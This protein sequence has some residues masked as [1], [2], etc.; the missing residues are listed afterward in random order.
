M[1]WGNVGKGAASG[2]AAGAAIGSVVPVIGTA[3]GAVA[4][5]IIGGLAGLFGGKKKKEQYAGLLDV[6]PELVDGAGNLNKELAQ[7]LINTKQVDDNT[8]QLIQNALDWSDAMEAANAQIKE[9][10]VELAGDLGVSLKNSIVEAWKAGED[11][12]KSMF[13][14]ASKSLEKFV[15]DLLYSTIFSEVFDEFGERLAK[16]LSPS[17]DGDI[18]DDYDWLMDEMNSRDDYFISLLEQVKNRAKERGFSAWGDENAIISDADKSLTGAVKGVTEETASLLA[19]QINAIRIN[20]VESTEIIRQQLFHLANI[21][22]NTGAI[23]VNTR[24][25]KAIY[26]KM[27]SGGDPLRSK[28]LGG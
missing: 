20:Q 13:D 26:D 6:F 24:Y 25:I 27:S 15:E 1:D 16:S 2:A 22:Q 12:S 23:D 4:G 10:T 19:G 28:G 21:S 7:T 8:R 3:I 9:V 14:A 11:A 5:A 18:L 17:G